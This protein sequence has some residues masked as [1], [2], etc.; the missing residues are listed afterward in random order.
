MDG[1]YKE[2][3]NQHE[4]IMQRQF[5]FLLALLAVVV[6]SLALV[7]PGL[8]YADVNDLRHGHWS[9]GTGVGFLGNTPDGAAEFALNGHAD[10][11]FTPNVSVGP[12]AQYA[13]AGNDIIFGLS[14][15]AK[16]WWGIPGGRNLAKIVVQ[17][18][19]GFVRAGI[20]DNDS[21]APADTYASFLIPVGVGLDYTVTKRVAVTADFLVNFTSLGETVHVGGRDV[22]LHTNVMPGLYLG[23]RF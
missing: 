23:M 17:G 2:T 20:K 16:Y 14:A 3:D 6:F 12:L 4:G 19:I 21:G 11:F 10:Y 15:Q 8:A 18:G 13:G 22:D 9:G 7:V 5:V 1:V